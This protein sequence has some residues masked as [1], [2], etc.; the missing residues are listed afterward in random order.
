MASWV[1]LKCIHNNVFTLKKSSFQLKN[2]FVEKGDQMIASPLLFKTNE[3]HLKS[4]EE[5]VS[6]F[7]SSR[8]F[9]CSDPWLTSG[10]VCA[11][12]FRGLPHSARR[13]FVE[14]F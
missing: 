9:A 3:R 12:G 4:V 5:S 11:K 10:S 8:L 14:S 1:P 13:N 2:K 7:K 6:L